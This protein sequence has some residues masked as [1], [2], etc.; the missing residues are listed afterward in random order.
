MVQG[1]IIVESAN[2][3]FNYSENKNLHVFTGT[4]NDRYE[5]YCVDHNKD[6]L[7]A[8]VRKKQSEPSTAS[9]LENFWLF[10]LFLLFLVSWSFYHGL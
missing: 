3:T 8:I 1:S 4:Q 10:R 9:K 7:M 6:V 5:D 2:V